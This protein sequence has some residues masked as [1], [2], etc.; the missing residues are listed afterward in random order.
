[1]TTP[2]TIRELVEES[3]RRFGAKVAYQ[4]KVGAGYHRLTFSELQLSQALH[5]RGGGR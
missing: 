1:M 3:A 2:S 5:T 4:T